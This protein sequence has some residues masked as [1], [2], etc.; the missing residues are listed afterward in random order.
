MKDFVKGLHTKTWEEIEKNLNVDK[1]L[2][3]LVNQRL[4]VPNQRLA[5]TPEEDMSGSDG[6]TF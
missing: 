1:W 5:R 6:V 3:N 2:G 4:I